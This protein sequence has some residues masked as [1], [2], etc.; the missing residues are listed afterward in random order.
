MRLC[1]G[2]IHLGVCTP[3]T[4]LYYAQYPSRLLY[5]ALLQQHLTSYFCG[6]TL[7]NAVFPV[8][9]IVITPDTSSAATHGSVVFLAYSRSFH[10]FRAESFRAIFH[11]HGT[12][13]GDR[14]R[15]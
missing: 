3:V 12:E 11:P 6:S 13:W 8:P 5:H 9:V 10:S 15:Y 1:D 4:P 7:D 2:R 14:T